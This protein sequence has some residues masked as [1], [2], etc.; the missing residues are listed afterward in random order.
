MASCVTEGL[1]GQQ[2]TPI[3]FNCMNGYTEQSFLEQYSKQILKSMS[4]K[5]KNIFEDSQKYL[6][7]IRPKISM[8]S[9]QGVDIKIDYHISQKDIKQFLAEAI[10]IPNRIY[11]NTGEWSLYWMNIIPFGDKRTWHQRNDR[12]IYKAW[13]VLC[14]HEFQKQKNL[15]K[16][17]QKILSKSLN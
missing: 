10:E 11:Q 1:S 17:S 16:F 3:Y 12:K 13:R 8:N 5:V 2:I 14:F 15:T 7:N 9:V 6:P 4:S